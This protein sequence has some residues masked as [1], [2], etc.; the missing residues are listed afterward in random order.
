MPKYNY[1]C[2]DCKSRAEE[3]KGGVL[4]DEE[5]W[6]VI[7]E[8][9]HGMNPGEK[10]LKYA[11]ECPRCDGVNTAKTYIGLQITGYV[12]GY[13][14]LDRAGCQRDMNLRKLTGVD[15]DTG[16]TTDPYA[17]MRSPGEVDDLKARLQRGGKH[18]PKPVRFLNSGTEPRETGMEQAVRAAT[19]TA[20]PKDD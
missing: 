2:N 1:Q 20:T 5:I 13:G 4:T 12:R 10:E 3:I 18:D 11:R 7:F 17:G 6:E 16:L 9:S 8:T 19:S 15:E 14:Y